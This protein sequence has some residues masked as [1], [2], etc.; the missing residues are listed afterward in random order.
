ML[1]READH[2]LVFETLATL[3]SPPE[4]DPGPGLVEMLSGMSPDSAVLGPK[5]VS[6]ILSGVAQT[7]KIQSELKEQPTYKGKPFAHWI[8]LT[9]TERSTELLCDALQAGAALAVT[10]DEK[11]TLLEVAR[12]LA[13]KYG[14][15]RLAYKRD[16][17]GR[18]F[19]NSLDSDNE[20]VQ[21]Y[22]A[23]GEVIKLLT[24]AE[25]IQFVLDELEH[26]TP[27]SIGFC[28]HLFPKSSPSP[29]TWEE[30]H[31][32]AFI[33]QAP[34][35]LKLV[36]AQIE[37]SGT[38]DGSSRV[39][40]SK[41]VWN[42]SKRRVWVA[43]QTRRSEA[44]FAGGGKRGYVAG[45]HE[46][47][48]AW[49]MEKNPTLA[50]TIRQLFLGS[51]AST[52]IQ[53][54]GLTRAFWPNDEE[55]ELAL[56][57]SLL[58]PSVSIED[59]DASYAYIMG[60][61]NKQRK[62]YAE[63]LVTSPKP[64]AVQAL[65]KLLDNQ[66]GPEDQRIPVLDS[67]EYKIVEQLTA[68]R[69]TTKTKVVE[70]RP[71][72]IHHIV[73]SLEILLEKHPN[74]TDEDIKPAIH[75]LLQRVVA[76]EESDRSTLKKELGDF[77]RLKIF[78]K[79]KQLLGPGVKPIL[80]FLIVAE[81]GRSDKDI[82]AAAKTQAKKQT[83]PL[84]G[85]LKN[86]TGKTIGRW[87]N[88][89]LQQDPEK[90]V[91]QRLVKF[92]PSKDCILRDGSTG[93][94]VNA[95]TLTPFM[96]PTG[97]KA[98]LDKQGI[99]SVQILCEQPPKNQ[100]VTNANIEFADVV[101]DESGGPSISFRMT[102]EGGTLMS[103]L[104]GRNIKR[105]LA[106]VIKNEA[107]SAPVIQS[108]ISTRGTITGDFTDEEAKD[109]LTLLMR[110][111]KIEKAVSKRES[112]SNQS[113]YKGKSFA[114]WMKVTKT[115]RSTEVLSDALAAGT[116]LAETK[117]EK[118][119]LLEV[120]RTLAR[121]P[122]SKTL[123]DSLI[124][125]IK[126]RAPKEV[127][128]FV[129]AELKNG[130]ADSVYFCSRL[131]G[132]YMARKVPGRLLAR[133]ESYCSA[134]VE[135]APEMLRQVVL[136]I[137][138]GETRSAERF[139]DVLGALLKENLG[140]RFGQSLI[141]QIK[142]QNKELAPTIR[143]LFLKS[144]AYTRAQLTELTRAYWQDDEQIQL[145]LRTDVFNPSTQPQ[146]RDHLYEV[147][148][149]SN[150]P[151][152][153]ADWS[154]PSTLL[155]LEKLLDNQLGPDAQRLKFLKYEKVS[156][157]R[158]LVEMLTT[159]FS[160]ETSKDGRAMME[161]G[162]NDHRAL[163][164]RIKVAQAIEGRPVVVRHIINSILGITFTKY[165]PSLLRMEDLKSKPQ[166]ELEKTKQLLEKI[167]AIEASE[168]PELKADLE[169]MKTLLIFKSAKALHNKIAEQIA[170]KPSP[171]ST[172]SKQP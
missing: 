40:L 114:H 21:Y 70:G 54:V 64:L 160:A 87:I 57:S 152:K 9:K 121:K 44:I 90:K 7:P 66:L 133:N 50:P 2:Q 80:E 130:T 5:E 134:I 123:V 45:V 11:A 137:E 25:I 108:S 15:A 166:E 59:R 98:W 68:R 122:D 145:T 115:E 39:L 32:N 101:Q 110:E 128:Q 60:E 88:L 30:T 109:I 93:K 163:E 131:I 124:A 67:C 12:T 86:E 126:T 4:R 18:R 95:Q 22:E 69:A 151:F 53:L 38:K 85:T 125:S 52:K 94:L 6:E 17:E 83:T 29:I 71:A 79:A 51:S 82:L 159:E 49:A 113:K 33:K 106:I 157:R 34:E 164:H 155:F 76:I 36:V 14:A 10:P 135:Q 118:S 73:E 165:R 154:D 75:E 149:S 105:T 3:S 104:T 142:K 111:T 120:V 116:K 19:T 148:M 143:E 37:Q 107:H 41:V 103:R 27:Q 78:E 42:L 153:K 158:S 28:S 127:V 81:N 89:A 172:S 100:L 46:E 77:R 140:N 96:K 112:L 146:V 47:G 74:D 84:T 35:L 150:R 72:T 147:I 97:F 117:E 48:V 171:E 13:R 23:M 170:A 92:V 26:G 63:F 119:E 102:T 91:D 55:V 31:N 136:R 141:A 58:D 43:G 129:Q 8:N 65:K 1:G 144:S 162:T 61:N 56:Q 168:D 132:Q 169:D 24:P 167:L 20:L 161:M 16:A 138:R 139:L 62:T 99:K 156:G